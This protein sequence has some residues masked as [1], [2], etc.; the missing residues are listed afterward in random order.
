[1]VLQKAVVLKK[2]MKLM[3]CYNS[4]ELGVIYLE[5]FSE[6]SK[7]CNY[8][9]EEIGESDKRC[10]HCGSLVDVTVESFEEI[11]DSV[12]ENTPEEN[13]NRPE[14]SP[15][16]SNDNAPQKSDENGEANFNRT[17]FQEERS[18]RA[19][20]SPEIRPQFSHKAY[21]DNYEMA[22]NNKRNSLSNGVKVLLTV[23]CTVIPGLGQLAG[24]IVSIVFMNTQE[25][26]ED[27]ADKR[28][29]G[30]ALLI[31]CI[32]MFL[33]SCLGCFLLALLASFQTVG[34]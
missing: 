26:V 19:E 11:N 6:K 27:Y 20:R 16:L 1:M 24:I 5:N 2:Y 9:G 23:V 33:L 25:N 12:E 3:I 14:N 21:S 30:L 32:V 29:F 17:G 13:G 18:N 10:S 8:C 28:S 15:E 31:A 22:Q 34:Y 4:L 7:R